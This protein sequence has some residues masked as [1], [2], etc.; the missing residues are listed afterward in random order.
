MCRTHGVRSVLV[1]I[2]GSL[3]LDYVH[4]YSSNSL[5]SVDML[6]PHK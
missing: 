4:T 3:N 5:L 2:R 1:Q 6:K